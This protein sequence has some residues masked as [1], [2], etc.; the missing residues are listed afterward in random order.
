[1]MAFEIDLESLDV[2]VEL[3]PVQVSGSEVYVV[4]VDY[5]AG[6]V[7]QVEGG[8]VETLV[9]VVGIAGVEIVVF[10]VVDS[11]V[12]VEANLVGSA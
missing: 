9:G 11:E 10:V 2:E 3:V 6:F 1:M 7:V 4:D 12:V 5:S 8:V